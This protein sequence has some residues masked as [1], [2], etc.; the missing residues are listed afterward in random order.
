MQEKKPTFDYYAR[1][2]ACVTI[3]ITIVFYVFSH[4]QV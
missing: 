4:L 3:D 1:H 2:L